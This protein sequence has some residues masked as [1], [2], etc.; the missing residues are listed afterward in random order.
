[1][2]DWLDTSLSVLPCLA[3]VSSL[4]FHTC[5]YLAVE[6]G[7]RCCA[8]VT[9]LPPG[10]ALQDRWRSLCSTSAVATEL[11]ALSSPR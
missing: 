7:P 1:M 9:V 6:R 8:I 3:F 2:I 4:S 11:A 5:C 10:V